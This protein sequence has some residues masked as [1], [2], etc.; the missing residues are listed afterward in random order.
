MRSRKI[1]AFDLVAK[2]T[3]V[4][5]LRILINSTTQELEHE[6]TRM[7]LEQSRETKTAGLRLGE[8]HHRGI[9]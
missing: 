7:N 5:H 2:N 1:Q 8:L 9:E 4:F 6:R 3:T